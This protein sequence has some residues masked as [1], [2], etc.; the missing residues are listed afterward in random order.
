MLDVR[1]LFKLKN[2]VEDEYEHADL[3]LN[4]IRYAVNEQLFPTEYEGE[5]K[6]TEAFIQLMN[7]L[8]REHGISQEQAYRYLYR[9]PDPEQSSLD[10]AI[11]DLERHAKRFKMEDL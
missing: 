7:E 1:F 8:M 3:R 9:K 5:R 6:F 11:E 4:L 10:A 2:I